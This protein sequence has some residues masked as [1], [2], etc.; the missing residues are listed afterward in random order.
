MVAFFLHSFYFFSRMKCD[1]FHV[2]YNKQY[3]IRKMK[4]Q[5]W[6]INMAINIIIIIIKYD[7]W[8]YFRSIFYV[9]FWNICDKDL[10]NS[11][12]GDLMVVTRKVVFFFYENRKKAFQ[13]MSMTMMMMMMIPGNHE[14]DQNTYDMNKIDI[15]QNEKRMINEMK[16]FISPH[17]HTHNCDDSHRKKILTKTKKKKRKRN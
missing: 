5:W 8:S 10:S 17:T 2:S 6:H 11:K 4:R 13:S 7:K 14:Q 12:D 9:F 1:T 16:R 3:N 15:D